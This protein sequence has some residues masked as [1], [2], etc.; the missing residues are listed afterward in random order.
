ML[1][2][3]PYH[4]EVVSPAS[5][6]LLGA[7]D[8]LHFAY[9]RGHDLIVITKN[10]SDFLALHRAAPEHPGI[11]LIYQDNRPSDMRPADIAR[12]IQNLVDAGV[13]IRNAVHEL[14]HWRYQ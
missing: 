9:A 1:R 3:P 10:P 5:A 12:A 7:N 2:G 8:E 6:G 13:P 14:N 4:H 11:F